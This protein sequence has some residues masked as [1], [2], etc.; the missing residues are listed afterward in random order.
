MTL[1]NTIFPLKYATTDDAASDIASKNSSCSGKL[2]NNLVCS[3]DTPA[4][5]INVLPADQEIRK[6]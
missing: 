2:S 3:F 6:N 1:M 4:V 5:W